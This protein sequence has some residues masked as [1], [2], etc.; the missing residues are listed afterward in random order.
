[1]LLLPRFVYLLVTLCHTTGLPRLVGYHFHILRHYIITHW[2]AEH[3]PSY[4]TLPLHYEAI[5]IS[6]ILPPLDYAL[7]YYYIHYYYYFISLV[8][9]TLHT[10]LCHTRPLLSLFSHAIGF[11][12]RLPAVISHA[13]HYMLVAEEYHEAP[14]SA[15]S[16][17]HTP[18][19]VLPPL[20]RWVNAAILIYYAPPP[21]IRHTLHHTCQPWLSPHTI[22]IIIIGLAPPQRRS[23][24]FNI[25]RLLTGLMPPRWLFCHG[26]YHLYIACGYDGEVYYYCCIC[27]YY[28][29]GINFIARALIITRHITPPTLIL[30]AITP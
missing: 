20:L 8:V 29:H 21:S 7:H 27:Y 6:F 12:L 10:L 11:T 2:A 5:T 16:L 15:L 13:G 25:T 22:I 3:T 23:I 28:R 19:L 17:V 18:W 30:H 1:M 24:A 26:I 4:Y 14:F 9:I